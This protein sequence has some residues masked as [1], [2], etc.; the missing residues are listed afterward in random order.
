MVASDNP[1]RLEVPRL[2]TSR[3][4]MRCCAPM[5]AHFRNGQPTS[6]AITRATP[7]STNTGEIASDATRIASV[8]AR[9]M[10]M[11]PVAGDRPTGASR[12]S[13]R[14]HGCAN[15][16]Y[17]TPAMRTR[18]SKIVSASP[19]RSTCSFPAGTG[20]IAETDIACISAARRPAA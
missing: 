12:A 16:R 17:S 19:V 3:R 4:V 5:S 13:L 1:K 14:Q 20:R 2:I 10:T 18:S 11:N 7:A 15:I 9:P 8:S 6:A